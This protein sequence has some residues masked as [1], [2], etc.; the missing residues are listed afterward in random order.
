MIKEEFRDIPNFRGY[1]ISNHG[2]VTTPN[3]KRLKSH[4]NGKGYHK[5]KMT[6]DSGESKSRFVQR[7]VAEAFIYNPEN[8]PQVNH[9]DGIRDN[10]YVRNL[11]WVTNSENQKHIAVNKWFTFE[12]QLPPMDLTRWVTV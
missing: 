9:I 11:E 1:K 3:G 10:N 5:V 2:Y 8:K 4:D 6:S 12:T 7:L